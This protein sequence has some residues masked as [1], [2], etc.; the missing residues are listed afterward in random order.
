MP[1]FLFYFTLIFITTILAFISDALKTNKRYYIL[2]NLTYVISAIIACFFSSVRYGIGTDYKMYSNIFYLNGN[3]SLAEAYNWFDMEV[4]WLLLN[5]ILYFIDGDSQILFI[6]TSIII[7]SSFYLFIYKYRNEINIGLAI[8][9]FMTLIYIPSFNVIRQ[10]LAI[11]ISLFSYKYI[12]EKK[13]YKFLAVILLGTLFHKTVAVLIFIYYYHNIPIKG[14]QKRIFLIISLITVLIFYDKVIYLISSISPSFNKFLRYSSYGGINIRIVDLLFIISLIIVLIVYYRFIVNKDK[15]FI[16]FL[17][18]SFIYSIFSFCSFFT[19]YAIRFTYLF[20]IGL[21]ILP[22]YLL[23]KQK[24][25]TNKVLMNFA[26]I[27]Y[28]GIYFWYCFIL[29][30]QHEVLP[31]QSIFS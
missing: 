30:G 26:F 15:E 2:S 29:K 12:F 25:K 7:I 31:Y 5:K 14:I 28:F 6:I 8:F 10:Y 18:M 22:A 1:N 4:G 24:L 20:H 27:F 13:I 3:L 11:A 16:L 19:D 21:V 9:I 17:D 23:E